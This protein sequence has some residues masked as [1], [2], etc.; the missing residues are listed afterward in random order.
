MKKYLFIFIF[1]CYSVSGFT[2]ASASASVN[3][4]AKI[5]EPIKIDK[6]LD[7]NFGNII[8]GFNPGS[9][10]LSPEGSRIANGVQ[11]SDAAAGEVSP[12]E[13]KI[14]HGA[15]AYSITLPDSFTLI[16]QE[17]PNQI[18][19]IDQFTISP[20][21]NTGLE[22]VDVLRFGATLHLEA[23]QVSGNY[24]NANGFNVTVTYN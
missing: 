22:G 2:Q 7:L 1:F 13:A 21:Q 23:N 6:T 18:L 4:S 16:N 10:I 11:I 14:T 20:V 3:G 8:S 17:N 12:A 5:I 24:T 19:I 15:N 9:I